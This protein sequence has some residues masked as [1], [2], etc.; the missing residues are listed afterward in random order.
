MSCTRNRRS[1]TGFSCGDGAKCGAKF[2]DTPCDIYLE[3]TGVHSERKESKKTPS[4]KACL[5]HHQFLDES[6]SGTVDTSGLFTPF[7]RP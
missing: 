7:R 5:S 6:T 2:A 1:S 3:V 4:Q